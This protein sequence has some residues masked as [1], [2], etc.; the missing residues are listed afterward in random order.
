V[1]TATLTEAMFWPR[2]DEHCA[3]TGKEPAV[4]PAGTVT[5]SRKASVDSVA[6]GTGLLAAN[7]SA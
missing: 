1:P 5:G 2:S 6:R 3:V 4:V 7:K